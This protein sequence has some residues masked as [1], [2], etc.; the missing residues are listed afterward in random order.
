[1]SAP[2]SAYGDAL[3]FDRLVNVY[4]YTSNADKLLQAR[5][6][7]A[8]RGYELRHFRIGSEP[9]DE[10]YSLGTETLL[11]K[12]ITQVNADFNVRSLFFV[13]DTSL[14]IDALSEEFDFP[15][16]AVKDWFGTTSFDEL[17]RQI[18]IRG[19][20]R[21]ALVRSDIALFLPT[22][23][24]PIFFHGETAGAVATTPPTFSPSSQYPWLTPD[25]FNGWF[26]PAGASRRLGETEFEDSLQFDFR[27]KSIA[28]LIDQID[29]LN[30]AL[31]LASNFY[32]VRRRSSPSEPEQPLLTGLL[33]I[34]KRA[35]ESFSSWVI[36]VPGRQPSVIISLH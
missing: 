25:T 9:Y 35:V 22:L 11:T 29:Q 17:D 20:D 16:L 23:S 7:F 30:A 1:M 3:R 27:A 13:E 21:R 18:R 4:F 26:I 28:S 36:N 24:R 2:L 10:D 15:G 14:R 31:N 34:D 5:L 32:V 12:A 19:G 6:I 8:R 33:P